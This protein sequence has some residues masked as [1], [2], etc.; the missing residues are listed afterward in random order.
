MWR[1]DGEPIWQDAR[2]QADHEHDYRH[3]INDARRWIAALADRLEVDPQFGFWPP[4]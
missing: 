2:L 4:G 1:K 3:D